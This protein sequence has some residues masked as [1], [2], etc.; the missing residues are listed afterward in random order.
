ME[1]GEEQ[2]GAQPELRHLIAMRPRDPFNEAMQA[3][4]PQVVRNPAGGEGF[5][6]LPGERGHM[7]AQ[8]LMSETA[9]QEREQDQGGPKDQHAG[10]GE[11]QPRSALPVKTQGLEFRESL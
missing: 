6:R 8:T 3:Q 4:P 9:G 10:I 1:A 7:L 5:G 2:A 11:A